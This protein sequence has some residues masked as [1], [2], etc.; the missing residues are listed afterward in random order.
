MNEQHGHIAAFSVAYLIYR[1]LVDLH[2]VDGE[3]RPCVELLVAN[4]ALEVLGLLVLDQDLFVV[5]LPVAIPAGNLLFSPHDNVVH[6]LSKC[7]T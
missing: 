5:K 6:V 1:L 4:V 2:A 7:N 3:S